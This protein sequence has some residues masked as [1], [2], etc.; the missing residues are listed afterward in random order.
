MK[1]SMKWKP[2]QTWSGGDHGVNEREKGVKEESLSREENSGDPIGRL[3]K[4]RACNDEEKLCVLV[5]QYL[6]RNRKQP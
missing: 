6:K 2:K 5:E 4:Q 3:V 1:L